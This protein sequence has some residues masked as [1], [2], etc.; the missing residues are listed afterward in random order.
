MI[1]FKQYITELF[2][3]PYPWKKKKEDDVEAVYQ[4]ATSAKDIIKVVFS[5]GWLRGIDN[6][7]F[8]VAGTTDTNASN[9]WMDY[10]A[11]DTSTNING[12]LI[13]NG[14][15]FRGIKT[16]VLLDNTG[17]D[18]GTIS[19]DPNSPPAGIIVNALGTRVSLT[20]AAI[21]DA[22]ATWLS[23]AWTARSLRFHSAADLNATTPSLNVGK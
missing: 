8:S 23:I 21:E 7:L 20:R 5:K 6:V 14:T 16:I 15:N 18:A 4:S 13:I 19:I 17:A 22:N 1:S 2:E 11:S 12:G 9:T 10:N 3:K